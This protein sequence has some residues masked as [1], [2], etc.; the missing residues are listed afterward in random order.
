MLE[1]NPKGKLLEVEPSAA[2][3]YSR[4]V[5]T[6]PVWTATVM[7]RGRKYQAS[8]IT[9]KAAAKT[10]AAEALEGM[11]IVCQSEPAQT[12]ALEARETVV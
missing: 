11:G 2:W 9:K 1:A 7:I 5:D 4:T 6:P 10:A 3:S 12:L 8:S